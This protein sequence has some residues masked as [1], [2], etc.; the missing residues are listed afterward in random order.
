[1]KGT[2]LVGAVR[3]TAL[4]ALAVTALALAGL[5][6]FGLLPGGRDAGAVAPSPHPLPPTP[7]E[8]SLHPHGPNRPLHH[9]WLDARLHRHAKTNARCDGQPA[10]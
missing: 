7:T 10:A 1:M 2:G 3:R 6:V 8:H 5:L 4:R 9:G